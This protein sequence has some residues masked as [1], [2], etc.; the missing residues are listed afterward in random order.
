MNIG[1]YDYIG[2][3]KTLGTLKDLAG[4]DRS[5]HFV[6]T[7]CDLPYQYLDD[8]FTKLGEDHFHPLNNNVRNDVS[9]YSL[10]DSNS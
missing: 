1:L 5:I 3:Q 2:K 7:C 8:Y 4:E 10:L 6:F 9:T